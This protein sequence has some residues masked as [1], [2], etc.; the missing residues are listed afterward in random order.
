MGLLRKIN[1]RFFGHPGMVQRKLID[2]K[3]SWRLRFDSIM[4]GVGFP[5]QKGVRYSPKR[6]L[7]PP[8]GD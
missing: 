6:F 2:F 3:A 8:L 1:L 5:L 7:I 4:L